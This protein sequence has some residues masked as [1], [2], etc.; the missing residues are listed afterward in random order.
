MTRI[1]S[2][3]GI[4]GDKSL[5]FVDMHHHST[6]SDGNKSPEFLAKVCRKAGFG[7]CISDHNQIRGSVYLAKQKGVFS[8]PCTEITTRQSKDILAYFYS[9]KD[10]V[11]FWEKEV[12]RKIKNNPLWNLNKTSIGLFELLDILDDYNGIA[13]AAHPAA[14]KPKNSLKLLKDKNFLKKIKAIESH[15]FTI[16][17]YDK[18]LGCVSKLNKPLT[19]GSDSHHVSVF[20]TMTGSHEF[21]VGSFLDSILRKKNII[22][23]QD[24]QFLR[25]QFEKWTI[26]K[27]NLHIRAPK[28]E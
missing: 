3:S 19:A 16:G 27:N 18:T 28:N 15:N 24:G 21:E 9:V 14:L 6:A 1:T 26:F 10:L 25:R 11:S 20:N 7:I 13:A 23:Y 2:D 22:Y 17:N 12:R 8:I 5:N 4:L